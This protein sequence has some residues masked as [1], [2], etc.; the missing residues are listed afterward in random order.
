MQRRQ[1]PQQANRPQAQ[2]QHRSNL[3]EGLRPKDLRDTI[4]DKFFIDQYKSKMG[5]DEDVVVL[6]FR[7]KDK[8][9]AI[10]MME[11]IEKGYPA[12]LDADMS[13]GEE[14]DGQ[15]AVFVEL[16]RNEKLPEEMV[17][18]LSGLTKL[19]GHEKW[20]FKYHKDDDIHEFDEDIVEKVVPLDPKSYKSKIKKITADQVEEVLDQGTTSVTDVDENFNITIEK[21]FAG[22]LEV[23]LEHIGNYNE[24]IEELEGPIQL[25]S[26]SNGQVLFLEKYLG[27]YVIHKINEKFIIKNGNKALII[28]KKDW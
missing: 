12:V 1:H 18:L 3:S 11:F 23:V 25:D 19:C 21:P 16:E 2:A 13:T 22:K 28:S 20:Y 15:Y 26:K 10:D 4:S 8:F 5:N 17:N 9:P 27:N 24:L 14:S 6:S 7:A